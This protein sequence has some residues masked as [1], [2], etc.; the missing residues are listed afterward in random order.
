MATEQFIG[1]VDRFE[2]DLAVVL[3]EQDGEVVDELVIDRDALPDAANH[4]DAVLQ[5]TRG[6]DGSVRE[7]SYDAE[8]TTE[9]KERAQSRF[10]RLSKRPPKDDD[11]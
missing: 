7:M 4:V 11:A 2:D 8:T 3:L 10:D 1:V 6:D 5:I 9:R